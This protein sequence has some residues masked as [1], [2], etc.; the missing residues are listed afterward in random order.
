MPWNKG[1]IVMKS[2]NL[3]IATV[4]AACIG[5]VGCATQRAAPEAPKVALPDRFHTDIAT[6]A[7]TLPASAAWWKVFGDPVLTALVDRGLADSPDIAVA[8]ARIAAARAE[9]SGARAAGRPQVQ[10]VLGSQ[11]VQQ[12]DNGLF[13]AA[14]RSGAFPERYSLHNAGLDASWE[15]DLFGA[16]RAQRH[17]AQ[18]GLDAMQADQ[19]ALRLSLP[20]EIARVYVEHL[21][22]A[23]QLASLQRSVQASGQRVALLAERLQQGDASEQEVS[24]A[25]QD[26]ALLSAQLPLLQAS[27]D[28][29]R[30]A[31][32]A[33][34]GTAEY[35]W[36]PEDSPMLRAAPALLDGAI[37]AGMPSDLLRRRPD[38]RGAEADFRRAFADHQYAIADQYPRFVISGSL[39]QESLQAGDLL[40]AASLAWNVAGQVVAPLYDGGRR[41]AA[42]AQRQ[43]QLDAAIASYRRTVIDALSDVEQ[44]L[45]ARQATRQS[46]GELAAGLAEARR[47]LDTEQS[48]YTAGD[49]ALTQLLQA[50]LTYEGSFTDEMRARGDALLGYVR[51]QKSL[52]SSP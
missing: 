24:H 38:I 37:V 33:L 22:V 42:T 19:D 50:R 26:V 20:A 44:S 14:T 49:S 30:H 13:G 43:A 17:S 6:P 12:S 23:Q 1:T 5:L 32:A 27:R 52:G 45:L 25:R 18:A 7:A 15:L 46:L 3:L 35:Q 8:S 41:K 36:L 29:L 21:V 4:V 11:R 2:S 39:L 31:M 48:R 51:L 10:A 40:K 47:Q 9:L 28:S 34:L 16:V